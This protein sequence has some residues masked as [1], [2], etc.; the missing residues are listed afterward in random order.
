MELTIKRVE[1]GS[2]GTFGTIIYKG[3]PFALTLEREWL[4]NA[5]NVSCI[6]EGDY[7]CERVNSP[8][9]GNT[10]EVTDVEGRSHILFHKGNLDD[11]SHGCILIGEQYGDLGANSGII[12]ST[13]GFNSFMVLLDEV[14]EFELTIT[15]CFGE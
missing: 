5:R 13:E 6:P 12:K 3:I 8:K 14:D 4:N 9:F 7:I 11:D 2:Q 15:N 10:F 1:T